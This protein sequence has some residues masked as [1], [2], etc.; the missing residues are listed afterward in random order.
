MSYET[1]IQ[2]ITD[3]MSRNLADSR[4]E[5]RFKDFNRTILFD[6][7]D[8]GETYIIKVENLKATIKPGIVEDP[9]I[10]I[11]GTCQVVD[12]VINGE[13]DAISAVMSKDLRVK[14]NMADI[15]DLKKLISLSQS[16]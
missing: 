13:V 7:E 5:R 2:S 10:S 16:F 15:L 11:V 12:R 6:I 3:T 8:I 14:G 4:Y 1:R 9:D